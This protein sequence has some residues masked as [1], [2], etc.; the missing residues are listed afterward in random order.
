MP[1]STGS[2]LIIDQEPTIVALL[3]EI[4][5]DAGYVAYPAPDGTRALTAIAHLLPALVI[6]DVGCPSRRGAE[7]LEAIRA[8]VLAT[9]PIVVMTTEPYDAAALLALGAV[10]CLVKPFDL[11]EL[12]ACVARAVQPSTYDTQPTAAA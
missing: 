10:A 9:T 7:L 1:S 12:L 4:L 8:A 5:T 3:V 6:L 2:I 11:D